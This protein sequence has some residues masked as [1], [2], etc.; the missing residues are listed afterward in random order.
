MMS[1]LV[2][3]MLLG[4]KCVFFGKRRK[5]VWQAALSLLV[6]DSVG[7][8]GIELFANKIFYPYRN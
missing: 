7:R 2:W 1:G 3:E 5:K 6:L 8:P 4:W